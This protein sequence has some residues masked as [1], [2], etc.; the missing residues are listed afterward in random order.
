MGGL[1]EPANGSGCHLL[2][3]G[4]TDGENSFEYQDLWLCKLWDI[5]ETAKWRWNGY[6][7]LDSAQIPFGDQV[8]EPVTYKQVWAYL[9]P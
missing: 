1:P 7:R 6:G 8:W 9:P 5:G 3:W 4:K 2:M